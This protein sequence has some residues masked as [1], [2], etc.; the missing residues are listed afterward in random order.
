MNNSEEV[1][2]HVLHAMHGNAIAAQRLFSQLSIETFVPMEQ[3]SV[4]VKGKKVIPKL[5]PIFLNLIFVK[6]TFARIKEIK[7]TCTYLYYLTHNV[8][9]KKQQMIVPMV[10]M[11]QFVNF[12]RNNFE[13]IDYVDTKGLYINKGERVKI[14]SGV[15]KG[16]EGTFIK[17]A[18]KRSKQIVVAIDGLL[19][20]S[21]KT[22][23]PR[24]IIEKQ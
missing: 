2:W 17:I 7:S 18:G 6:S 1:Q 9:G 19:A 24:Q 4:T 15:F 22:K 13:H 21:I 10:E 3:R 5:V 14:I 20:V 16:K 12:V 23:N 11:E 8:N